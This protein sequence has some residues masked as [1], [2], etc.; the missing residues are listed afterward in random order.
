MRSPKMRTC[1]KMIVLPFLVQLLMTPSASGEEEPVRETLDKTDERIKTAR[2][3][4]EELQRFGYRNLALGEMHAH[5]DNI[6]ADLREVQH[7]CNLREINEL[8]KS[9]EN[10]SKRVAYDHELVQAQVEYPMI[11]SKE[12]LHYFRLF[13]EHFGHGRAVET[14]GQWICL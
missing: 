7:G 1:L 4:F 12:E 14:V 3:Q 10:I 2:G 11:R 9:I 5:L 8:A 13:T 6:R